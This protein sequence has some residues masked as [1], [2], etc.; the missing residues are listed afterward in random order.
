MTLEFQFDP[1]LGLLEVLSGSINIPEGS[2]KQRDDIQMVIFP[3]DLE[4]ID[5]NAFAYCRNLKTLNLPSSLRSIGKEAFFA[6]FSLES[7]VIPNSVVSIGDYAFQYGRSLRSVHIGDAVTSIGKR[8][9][10]NAWVLSDLKL[11]DSLTTI[12]EKAFYRNPQ[13]IDVTIPDSVT[14]IGNEAF[15]GTGI[16]SVVL[17]SHFLDNPPIAAFE[18]GTEFT[19][20][21]EPN[22]NSGEITKEGWQSNGN[23]GVWTAE[24]DQLDSSPTTESISWTIAEDQKV[25]TLEG[26]DRLTIEG[27]DR[28]ALINAGSLKMNRGRDR[29]RLRVNVN[30]TALL[31]EGTINMG[32]GRDQ[33]DLLT[34][35]L[36]GEGTIKLGPGNDRFSGFGQQSMLNGGKGKDELK[37]PTGRYE[38]L[39]QEKHWLITQDERAMMISSIETVGGLQTPE[40]SLLQIKGLDQASTL[41]V[42][43]SSISWS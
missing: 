22:L 25:D 13:L 31:N 20:R 27:A 30:A 17:P 6:N 16:T 39:P 10:S 14:R 29:L 24:A 18:P 33:I 7:L 21:G 34:G 9:F 15:A 36:A 19:Y 28:P 5:S 12:G 26:H 23:S 37:L 38:L 40:A 11:G 41:L 3:D 42:D 35:S 43:G 2:F 32:K 8:T 4:T 1:S